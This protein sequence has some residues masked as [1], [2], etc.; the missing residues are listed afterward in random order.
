MTDNRLKYTVYSLFFISGISGLAYE[1][2]WL[3]MLSRLMGVTI[4]ATSTVLAAF[5]AGLAL[6]SFLFGRLVD[7]RTDW[8]RLYAL[9][10]FLI[11]CTAL[12]VPVALALSLPL[13]RSIHHLFPSLGEGLVM[14]ALIRAPVSFV[15][16]VV[17]T[18]LM[19]GTL[20]VLTAY[21]ARRDNLFGRNFSLLY[22]LNTLGA[23][24]GVSVSGFITLGELGER[25]TMVL[26]VI[27]NIFVAFQA[28]RL[29]TERANADASSQIKADSAEG[30]AVSPYP[31]RV[32][33]VLL[34]AF[35]VSGFSALAYEIIWTRQLILWLKTSIYAFSGML[36][37]F[38]AGTAG[39]SILMNRIVDRLKQPLVCF[40]LLELGVAFVSVL[41]L[42]LFSRL[43]GG[44]FGSAASFA[45]LG[46]AV[47]AT[48][49]VVLPL[50]L[51]FGMIFPIAGRCYVKTIQQAGSSVGRLYSANTVGS[52]F[53]SLVAGFC[54]IPFLGCTHTVLLLAAVNVGLGVLLLRLEPEGRAATRFAWATALV[55]LCVGYAAF[56]GRD[57]FFEAIQKRVFA[58]DMTR[59]D[60]T[61]FFHKEG[62]EGTVTSFQA[63]KGKH[64][65]VN[66]VGMTALATE[67][68]L[69]AHLPLLFTEN[70]QE[71]LIICFGMGTTLR[72]A[73]LY[74]RLQVTAVELVPEVLQTF[75][76]YHADA[77]Q[78]LK[79]PNVNTIVADGRNYLL[80]SDKHYDLIT[81]DPA[82]PIFSAG[83]V[84]L[85]TKEF[86]SLCRDHLTPQGVLCL[87][88]PGRTRLEIQSF[89]KTFRV[90]FPNTS[91][92]S[93]VHG[94]GFY[95]LGTARAAPGELF[96][97]NAIKLF[98]NPTL[99]DD[100]G[101]FDHDCVTLEQLRRLKLWTNSEIDRVAADGVVI[102]DDFPFT[103]FPLWRYLFV[104]RSR[105][106]P[107]EVL[108]RLGIV[109]GDSTGSAY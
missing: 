36:C 49:V 98:Q 94:W 72:S 15:V 105:W 32:R 39:G 14:S 78:I 70:P 54:L 77:D 106:I 4:Y 12:L 40:G 25:V 21:L 31:A 89:L 6:G 18:T 48:V 96:E 17:P 93:G 90:V 52:L 59:Q 56:S 9:L 84:N 1:I 20:P 61:I 86:L 83:T 76:F 92:W 107:D 53:G 82:P 26:G 38:L 13:Y 74:P 95:L 108:A 50:T 103:E 91:V 44:G 58:G 8:L 19:G 10:E 75:R 41:N 22:G 97:Q 63:G 102:T 43:G 100:L 28:Y 109:A 24:V 11:G 65:W 23:V 73:S 79:K 46:S 34:I 7:K 29:Y 62:V 33:T 64:L 2:V 87:W 104:D 30:Q 47:L 55:V 80:L 37:V 51:L 27:I 85:Y 35:A 69:M 57:P 42:L 68:K 88:V 66:G 16:L 71:A 3:R 81:I 67:T 101:Q 5:M 99:V 60:C 45:G